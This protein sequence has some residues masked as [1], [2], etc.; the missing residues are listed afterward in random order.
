MGAYCNKVDKTLQCVLFYEVLQSLSATIQLMTASLVVHVTPLTPGSE[1]NP[2]LRRRMRRRGTERRERWCVTR[3]AW[4]RA[5]GTG[6][7][8][9]CARQMQLTHS[10]Q[11]RGF[12]LQTS[13]LKC[14]ILVSKFSFFKFSL[15]RYTAADWFH[16]NRAVAPDG[17]TREHVVG[18]CAR[19][20]TPPDPQL[21][22]AGYPRGFKPCTYR[23]HHVKNRF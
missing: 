4:T 21:K 7:L 15:Y 12:K 3:R 13:N 20:L 8:W 18:R 10:L 1:C 5:T 23:A 16:R 6:T 22:G 14:D 17:L 2:T 11:A 19:R 9:G